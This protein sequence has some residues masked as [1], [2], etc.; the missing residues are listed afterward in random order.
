MADEHGL[1]SPDGPHEVPTGGG[2][3]PPG[4]AVYNV[5]AQYQPPLQ[6]SQH[7]QHVPPTH[8]PQ[9]QPQVSAAA[10]VAAALKRCRLDTFP[11]QYQNRTTNRGHIAQRCS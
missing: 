8:Q 9:T 10:T 6:F 5:H 11:L 3:S 2:A 4:A 7:P 1:L